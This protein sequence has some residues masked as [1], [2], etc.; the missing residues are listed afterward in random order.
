[1]ITFINDELA[2]A[3]YVHNQIFLNQLHFDN[4]SLS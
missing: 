2:N 3:L 4:Q 1:M